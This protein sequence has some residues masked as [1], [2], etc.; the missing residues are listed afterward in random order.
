VVRHDSLI[1]ELDAK[2]SANTVSA[3]A[4]WAPD[5]FSTET[6]GA[7]IAA[8]EVSS[9]MLRDEA[10]PQMNIHLVKVFK[11]ASQ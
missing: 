2:T 4:N 1:I 5:L 11:R 10:C 9:P 6:T 7:G 3:R 8:D